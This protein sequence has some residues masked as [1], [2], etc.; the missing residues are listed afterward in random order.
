MNRAYFPTIAVAAALA[1]GCAGPIDPTSTDPEQPPPAAAPKGGGSALR[2]EQAER[3]LDVGRDV[4]GA[5]AALEEVLADPAITPDQRD[6]ARLGLSRALEAGG[7]REGAI[8]AVEALLAEH[9]EGARFPLEEAAE[10]RL[11]MLVTGSDAKPRWHATEDTRPTPPF[12]R[13]LAKYFPL[14]SGGKGTVELR[15]LAFGGSE[16]VSQRLGTF[17]VDRGVREARREACPL[18][19]DHI[20]V[21]SNS[22]RTGSWVGI[23]RARAR[24]AD[25][26]AVFYFDLHDGRIPARYDAELPLPSAEIA[27][28]LEKGDGLVA[29]R[30]RPGAPPVVLVAAPREGQLADVEEALA[31]MKTIPSEPVTVPLKPPLKP[32]EI[33]GVVRASF[34]AYRRCYEAVLKTNPA[35]S[36]TARLHFAIRGDGSVDSLSVE[37]DGTLRDPAF[38]A[39]VTAAT[40]AL[41]FPANHAASPTTVTYPINFTPG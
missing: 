13:A 29:V 35:A 31:A 21:H 33:Q 7:D 24:L 1:A 37:T 22:G 25:A 27:A 20:S 30:E 17:A 41:A 8:A 40:R 28:R 5:R 32:Q 2:L 6:Q 4:A 15:I 3:S 26:L 19:D 39:C 12:A 34:G 16:E 38:E 11:R 14:P 23:A 9:P 10:G 36:G 18:C